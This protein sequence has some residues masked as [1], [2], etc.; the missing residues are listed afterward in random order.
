MI[1]FTLSPVT[2]KIIYIIR[3]DITLDYVLTRQH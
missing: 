1:S 3:K 2:W